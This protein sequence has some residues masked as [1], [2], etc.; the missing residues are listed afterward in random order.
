M[1]PIAHPWW[2]ICAGC[3]LNTVDPAA[4]P[5]YDVLAP[6]F[7]PDMGEAARGP[8]GPECWPGTTTGAQ[9]HDRMTAD[10]EEPHG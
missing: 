4:P 7:D 5:R 1:D 2:I 6:D 10:E 9:D 8:F 3:G